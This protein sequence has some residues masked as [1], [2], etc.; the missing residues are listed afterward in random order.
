MGGCGTK[1]LCF[2]PYWSFLD[3]VHNDNNRKLFFEPSF[4]HKLVLQMCCDVVVKC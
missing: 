1:Y 3:H 4:E 2:T